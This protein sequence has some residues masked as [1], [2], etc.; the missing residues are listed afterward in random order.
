METVTPKYG[1]P[2]CKEGVVAAPAPVQAIDKGM[3]GEGL[4]AHIVTSKYA[5]HLPLNR[6][7][8]IFLRHGVEL[9]RSTMCDWVARAA[10][11]LTPIYDVIRREILGTDYL[12]T[13]ETGVVILDKGGGSFKGRL[14]VYHDPLGG[15]T[16]FA[17]TRTRE[18][19]GPDDFLG[20]F[21]GFLQADAYTGYDGLFARGSIKEVACWAHARRKF[22]EA[23][24]TAPALADGVLRLIQ[25]MYQVEKEAAG[26]DARER[27]DLRQQ[28]SRPL[29]EK[30]DKLRKELLL[31]VLP[32]SPMGEALRYMNN[33]WTALNRYVDD[34]RLLIDNNN[35]ER[36][37]RHVAVGRKNWLFAGRFEG[38]RRA[39]ILYSLVSSCKHQGIDP[40]VYFRDVLIRVATHPQSRIAELTPRAWKTFFAANPGGPSTPA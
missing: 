28:R 6:L 7:E 5:D 33:Q 17:A 18:K 37:L 22:V 16:V 12:Q 26:K 36:E 8:G 15:R 24:E 38:A 1:C 4:L 23:R 11:A 27:K 25:E 39:A 20:S 21:K 14:W 19:A 9:D 30:L 2:K 10:F 13:D 3:A 34:G 35:A 29:L 31:K 32:K 40:F